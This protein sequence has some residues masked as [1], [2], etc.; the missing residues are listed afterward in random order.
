[1]YWAS[2]SFAR[3]STFLSNEIRCA[4]SL[5]QHNLFDLM[6]SNSLRPPVG[7]LVQ[8]LLAQILWYIMPQKY[9]II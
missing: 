6:A 1:M 8:F 5:Q 9:F 3:F 2:N 4:H 7:D